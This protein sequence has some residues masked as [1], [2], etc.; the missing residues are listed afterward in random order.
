MVEV[1]LCADMAVASKA[2]RLDG[3]RLMLHVIL[4][5]RILPMIVMRIDLM[6]GNG[7]QPRKF[8]W[9]LGLLMLLRKQ[10]WWDLVPR[11]PCAHFPKF[12]MHK[13]SA[14]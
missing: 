4:P 7:I 9:H 8:Q 1:H 6:G 14:I 13:M 2:T 5:T 10:I 3:D 12:R 11:L